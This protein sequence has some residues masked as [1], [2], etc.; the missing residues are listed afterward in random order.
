[1]RTTITV[2]V[3]PQERTTTVRR[4][5]EKCPIVCIYDATPAALA[6]AYRDTAEYLLDLANRIDGIKVSPVL[7]YHLNKC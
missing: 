5:G 4:A 3:D 2:I 1:M 6:S 7:D